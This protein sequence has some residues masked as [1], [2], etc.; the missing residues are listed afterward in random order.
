[1]IRKYIRDIP[2]YIK[3]YTDCTAETE[4]S[5]PS[6]LLHFLYLS[7]KFRYEKFRLWN[8][9]D[10]FFKKMDTQEYD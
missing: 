10:P 7:E 1:M 2:E 9:E 8:R 6:E 3:L 5:S 4:R